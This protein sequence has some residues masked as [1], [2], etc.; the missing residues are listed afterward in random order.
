M[1]DAVRD[2][3]S[4]W[5]TTQAASHSLLRAPQLRKCK[6][7][8]NDVLCH[9]GCN[10]DGT[11]EEHPRPS[12]R[13]HEHETLFNE[14]C[15]ATTTTT[16][17]TFT[18][19]VTTTPPPTASLALMDVCTYRSGVRSN[20]ARI[21]FHEVPTFAEANASVVSGRRDL[22]RDWPALL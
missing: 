7:D 21:T 1:P 5:L 10:D 4:T 6:H 12:L 14:D 8:I 3:S 22:G 11:E 19:L 20:V 9:E 17:P 18:T 16:S 2:A 13:T 15:L